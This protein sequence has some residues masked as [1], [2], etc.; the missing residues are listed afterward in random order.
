MIGKAMRIIYFL[1]VIKVKIQWSY[2]FELLPVIVNRTCGIGKSATRSS[3]SARD[4]LPGITLCCIRRRQPLIIRLLSP[5][6]AASSRLSGG[7]PYAFLQQELFALPESPD[8][9]TQNRIRSKGEVRAEQPAHFACRLK[10]A[11]GE[12]NLPVHPGCSGAKSLNQI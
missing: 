7:K 12:F 3:D 10:I 8:G 6:R 1:R 11:L 2:N 9:R 4:F 5:Y